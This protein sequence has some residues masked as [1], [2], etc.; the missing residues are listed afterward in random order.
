MDDLLKTKPHSEY[1][2]YLRYNGVPR[3]AFYNGFKESS[4]ISQLPSY[5]YGES[6]GTW[7]FG[8]AIWMRNIKDMYNY[9]RTI[10]GVRYQWPTDVADHWY[11]SYQRHNHYGTTDTSEDYRDY[12]G[13]G[14]WDHSCKPTTAFG[15]TTTG[16]MSIYAR[17][18]ISPYSKSLS[19][20]EFSRVR[21]PSSLYQYGVEVEG[22]QVFP[23]MFSGS[24]SKLRA[25]VYPLQQ[26]MSSRLEYK[27]GTV[28]F[29]KGLG[30]VATSWYKVT[31]F[32][33]P[34]PRSGFEVKPELADDT[35][36]WVRFA[37]QSDEA[38]LQN[39]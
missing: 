9:Y 16:C 4:F 18:M 27:R 14:N 24:E 39:I 28:V 33:F 25:H 21:Y 11:H 1:E 38:Y 2:W 34:K 35:I 37:E 10:D 12:T 3:Q 5:P 15:R 6:Y 31:E 36:I 32:E 8:A 20:K 23:L 7:P 19:L 13:G 17:K 30:A 26:Q 22:G 29:A